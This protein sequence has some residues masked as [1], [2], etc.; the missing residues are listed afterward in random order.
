VTPA[1]KD[2]RL[3][4]SDT[5][6]HDAAWHLLQLGQTCHEIKILTWIKVAEG[7]K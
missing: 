7:K 4:V 2:L 5:K 3:D 6:L 1:A